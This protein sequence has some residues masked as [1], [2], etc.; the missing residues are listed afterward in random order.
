MSKTERLREELMA[1]LWFLPL[2][3][4]LVL[5]L[6]ALLITRVGGLGVSA[7]KT[8]HA[9]CAARIARRGRRA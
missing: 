1:L 4:A 3:L 8:L 9:V 6:T 7:A 2:A 5:A